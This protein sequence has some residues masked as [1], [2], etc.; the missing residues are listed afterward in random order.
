[1]QL[2]PL[3]QSDFHTVEAEVD[4]V[5]FRVT[6]AVTHV[7]LL[8][9][10]HDEVVNSIVPIAIEEG[11]V[12]IIHPGDAYAHVLTQLLSQRRVFRRQHNLCVKYTSG[13]SSLA[14]ELHQ[15]GLVCLLGQ[16]DCFPIIAEPGDSA[17]IGAQ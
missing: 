11:N 6:P 13:Y 17:V 3:T 12:D 4:I 7:D 2:K 8:V 10:V 15:H 16:P 9:R 1:M 5:R 14:A